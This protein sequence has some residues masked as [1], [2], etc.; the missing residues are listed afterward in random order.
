M[1]KKLQLSDNPFTK[2]SLGFEKQKRLT[3]S[4]CSLGIRRQKIT[5]VSKTGDYAP[6]GHERTLKKILTS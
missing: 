5:K 3:S 1:F 4:Q 6:S 2:K